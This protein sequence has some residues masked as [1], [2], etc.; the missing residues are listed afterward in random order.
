MTYESYICM[1]REA[2]LAKMETVMPEKRLQ[3]CL[4]VEKAARE[5]AE[6]FGLD[7]EKAGL[8]GLLHDYA[9]KVSDEEFLAL[10]DKYQLDPDLKNWGNNVWHGMVGIY[11]I[12]E[13]LGIKDAE[14]LR[15][16]EIHTVGSDTMS[17]LDKVVYVAD[18]I[19][20]NRDF[21]GVDKAREL[22]QRSLNQAVAY[23]TARTVEHLAHKGMPIYPQ[24]LETYNAF[25]GYLKEIEEN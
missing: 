10:I 19:E 23:E 24:T 8:A 14:I 4:G 7:I 18:Y 11:K 3:H 15:A 1:G 20:H 22:A 2:L 16:I 13:D 12:Q 6:R 9:K 5:L 17:E 25:V 21:P